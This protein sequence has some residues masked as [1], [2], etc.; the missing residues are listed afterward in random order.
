MQQHQSCPPQLG[1][2]AGLKGLTLG[3][4]RQALLRPPGQRNGVFCTVVPSTPSYQR[5]TCNFIYCVAVLGSPSLAP[6]YLAQ[7]LLNLNSAADMSLAHAGGGVH[8]EC[9]APLVT[10]DVV[11]RNQKSATAREYRDVAVGD[12]IAFRWGPIWSGTTL[13]HPKQVADN[14]Q[15][16][17]LQHTHLIIGLVGYACTAGRRGC[18]RPTTPS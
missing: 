11:K 10:P 8:Q 13:A 2:E 5:V 9:V 14:W 15:A 7:P 17:H 1:D 18:F 3:R 6:L 16:S 12:G 4:W